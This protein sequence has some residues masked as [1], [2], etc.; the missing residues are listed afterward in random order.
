MDKPSQD[1]TDWDSGME[2]VAPGLASKISRNFPFLGIGNIMK[3]S[4]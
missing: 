3:H 4:K 2:G 1:V